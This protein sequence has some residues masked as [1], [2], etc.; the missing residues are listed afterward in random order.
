MFF[1]FRIIVTVAH[2]MHQIIRPGNIFRNIF[3]CFGFQ[4]I[5]FHHFNLGI[6]N[7][8]TFG[9]TVF[10]PATADYLITLGSDYIY[11]SFSDVSGSS[12][13][14]NFFHKFGLGKWKLLQLMRKLY[15]F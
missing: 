13:K 1:T 3:Q 4:K 2:G 10:I 8:H 12:G 6:I 14:K 5:H 7:I 15:L 11:H 9:K